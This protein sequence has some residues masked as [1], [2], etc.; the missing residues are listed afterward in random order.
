MYVRLAFAVAAHLDPEI[1]VVDEV[2]AVGDAEFQK[3]CLGKMENVAK[4]GRT[5]LFVSH[6]MA[7]VS[8]LCQNGAVLQD[9]TLK[10]IFPIN[11]AINFYLAS[12]TSSMS[13][14]HPASR[15][16]R[17]GNGKA[18]IVDVKTLNAMNESVSQ[19]P[20]NNGA[21][22]FQVDIDGKEFIKP[23]WVQISINDALN[24]CIL[25]LDSRAV[26][27]EFQI[28]RGGNSVTCVLPPNITLAKGAYSVNVAIFQ[29]LDMLDYLQWASTFEIIEGDFYGTGKVSG[30]NP[31][32]YI[33][34]EW[35]CQ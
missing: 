20:M 2:L 3:K 4:E 11:D 8:S 27:L 30:G 32:I 19:I 6:N 21:L 28:K 31:V 16:D 18:L 1:L 25:A 7:A 10:S 23:A 5:V 15:T 12:T 17:R 24:R 29:S 14:N 9:G 33:S 22:T 34:Q 35:K 13:H 26:N